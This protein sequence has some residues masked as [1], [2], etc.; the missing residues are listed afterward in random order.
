MDGGAVPADVATSLPVQSNDSD[1][2][3][4]NERPEPF[5]AA[6]DVAHMLSVV[7]PGRVIGPASE[8]Y[9]ALLLALWRA[10]PAQ[11]DAQLLSAHVA[12][13]SDAFALHYRSSERAVRSAP[14]GS[15]RKCS[16][17]ARTRLAEPCPGL[18]LYLRDGA[19]A[20]RCCRCLSHRFA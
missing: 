20:G 2:S 14:G 4:S 1:A 16:S 12:S 6:A 18:C 10:L 8:G 7:R 19:P 13:N 15:P 11:L 3:S 17:F 9:Q 5:S